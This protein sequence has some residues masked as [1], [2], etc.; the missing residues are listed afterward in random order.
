VP[1]LIKLF[2]SPDELPNR[3]PILTLLSSLAVAARDSAAKSGAAEASSGSEGAPLSPYKDSVLGAMT[4]GLKAV[5]SA[6]PAIE[7]LNAMV[8]TPG[9][10]DDEELGFVVQKLNDLVSG[11]QEDSSDTR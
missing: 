2:L 10:L 7:G 3:G 1:H 11:E 4:V 9:L 6:Q 5:S 8:T